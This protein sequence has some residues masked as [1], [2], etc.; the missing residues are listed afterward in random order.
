[1]AEFV[2]EIAERGAEVGICYIADKFSLKE[3][4]RATVEVEPLCNIGVTRS[5]CR[6][7]AARQGATD[8]ASGTEYK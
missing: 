5:D 8:R 4:S 6:G 3:Q 1:M 2:G 7:L